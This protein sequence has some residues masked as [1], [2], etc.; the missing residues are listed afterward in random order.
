MSKKGLGMPLP[1]DNHQDVVDFL[2]GNLR[3]KLKKSARPFLKQNRTADS[4]KGKGE[5]VPDISLFSKMDFDKERGCWQ[6]SDIVMSIEVV[7][8][9]G[10]DHSVE[11]IEKL[12]KRCDTLREAFLYNYESKTWT[13]YS[14]QEDGNMALPEESDF[15]EIFNLHLDK[16][17][18]VGDSIEDVLKLC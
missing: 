17:A 10:V 11:S 2:Y 15:S 1:Y 5:V 9:Y 14:R 4:V 13:R 16:F 3:L 8:N 6:Y 18:K 12:F 7:R